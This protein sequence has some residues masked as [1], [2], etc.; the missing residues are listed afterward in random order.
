[1]AAGAAGKETPELVAAG[2]T[3]VS[4]ARFWHDGPAAAPS[5]AGGG[6]RRTIGASARHGEL[7]FGRGIRAGAP[8]TR[9]AD[10]RARGTRCPEPA[11][12]GLLRA[13]AS[14]RGGQRAL[15]AS[16]PEALCAAGEPGA[17][18]GP[19]AGAERA[20]RPGDPAF[21]GTAGGR[22]H[23]FLRDGPGRRWGRRPSSWPA[24]AG[25]GAR[26]RGWRSTRNGDCVAGST[27]VDRLRLHGPWAMGLAAGLRPKHP[28][29][30]RISP[31]SCAGGRAPG[32]HGHRL[33]KRRAVFGSGQRRHGSCLERRARP[34]LTGLE[35]TAATGLEG[36]R[37]G[38]GCF[39]GTRSR[40]APGRRRQ[41]KRRPRCPAGTASAIT[42]IGSNAGRGA[43]N[44]ASGRARVAAGLVG[45]PAPVAGSGSFGLAGA[46][47]Q[48]GGEKTWRIGA[49]LR[50]TRA[51]DRHGPC[52]DRR[53]G[54][55]GRGP[56]D[57]RARGPGQQQLGPPL[58]P[59]RPRG[60]TVP[61]RRAASSAG[62][63]GTDWRRAVG[64]LDGHRGRRP[65]QSGRSCAVAGGGR[66][67]GRPRPVDDPRGLFPERRSD[68]GRPADSGRGHVL[69][70]DTGSLGAKQPG[71]R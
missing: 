24:R 66:T 59:W 38:S 27:A 52:V 31:T 10:G 8:T 7:V 39:T 13:E 58:A 29:S 43:I 22:A 6:R 2:P 9:S 19:S 14:E 12:H 34:R 32:T 68:C 18:L 56:V 50:E 61:G 51:G 11:P 42:D 20:R 49:R 63:D 57:A 60:A 47:R 15:V 69:E 67:W 3:R 23:V 46:A 17:V 21:L 28:P 41:G 62:A 36:S 26:G 53:Q 4:G 35:K 16:A 54:E 44:A 55:Q 70:L 5:G 25:R 71:W 1:M 33:A 30:N 48:D 37:H 45:G 65:A 64:Q 40:A